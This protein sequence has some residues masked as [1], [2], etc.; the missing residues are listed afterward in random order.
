MPKAALTISA[1]LFIIFVMGGCA[2]TTDKYA[3]SDTRALRKQIL[4]LERQVTGLT[5]SLQKKEQQIQKLTQGSRR[6]KSRK[7]A[8]S[9]L[10]G[11]TYYSFVINIQAA[12]KNAGF[13][14]GLIDGKMGSRTHNAIKAFQ[15]KNDLPVNGRVDKQTWGLLRKHL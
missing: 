1:G 12:L 11:K 4:S 3:D 9:K 5:N 10:K 2:T 14:P 15:N 8:S 13:N 6:K 7:Q